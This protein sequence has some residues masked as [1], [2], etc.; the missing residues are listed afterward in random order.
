MPENQE[1]PGGQQ[2]GVPP[3]G[4]NEAIPARDFTSGDPDTPSGVPWEFADELRDVSATELTLE[5]ETRRR[6]LHAAAVDYW[7]L[8]F[9]CITL[10]WMENGRCS[11][12]RE[13]CA[14]PGKHPID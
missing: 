10:H 4:E 7:N 11:C 12:G 13:D 9:R 14:S 5:Q 8:G 1:T 3:S 2:P 6:E